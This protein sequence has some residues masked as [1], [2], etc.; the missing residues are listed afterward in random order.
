MQEVHEPG[1]ID[2]PENQSKH[3]ATILITKKTKLLCLS[4][5]DLARFG[6]KV[7]QELQSFATKRRIFCQLRKSAI[8]VSLYSQF[9]R[10]QGMI[11]YSLIFNGQIS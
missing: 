7:Q 3:I 11:Q 1:S 6:R 10:M 4:A 5:S 2:E 9:G 8:H